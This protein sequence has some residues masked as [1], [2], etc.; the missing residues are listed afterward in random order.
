MGEHVTFFI[1]PLLFEVILSLL[2]E[3]WR[4][5]RKWG[6]VMKIIYENAIPTYREHTA[7]PAQRPVG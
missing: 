2:E 4:D 3:A 5:N 1:F 6:E 7:S